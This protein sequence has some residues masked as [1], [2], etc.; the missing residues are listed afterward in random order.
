MQKKMHDLAGTLF[1]VVIVG[2]IAYLV[3]FMPEMTAVHK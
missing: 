2:I 3:V 1:L